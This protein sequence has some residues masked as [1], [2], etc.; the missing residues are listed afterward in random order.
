MDLELRD[1]VFMVAASSK[2]LGFGIA[3]ALAHEGAR[4]S[5]ASRS[6]SEISDAASRI[7]ASTGAAAFGSVFDATSPES[8]NT[9]VQKTLT[10]FGRIDGLVVNAGGPPLGKFESFDDAAWQDAFSLTLLSSV[11]MIRAVLPSLREKHRSGSILCVTSS[12]VKEP[13]DSLILS[14]VFRAGVA[15]LV[16]TLSREL[17][18]DHIRINSLIPGK[19][20]TERIRA[21]ERFAS[22]EQGLTPAQYR[23]QSEREI[24]MGRYGSSAEFGRAAVFLLSA[25]SSYITGT[26]LVVD[27][28]KMRA[29][30]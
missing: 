24:P 2:G 18:K 23:A 27:G 30:G 3:E 16:K 12:A 11:R 19:I 17:A 15:S 6:L 10:H 4:V 5:M 22:V 28:G 20:D 8:I 13:I 29:L 26:S 1:K 14:N 21:L 7:Q 9:W 25:A